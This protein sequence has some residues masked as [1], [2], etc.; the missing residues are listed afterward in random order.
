MSNTRTNKAPSSIDLI[1]EATEKV[2]R[3][4]KHQGRDKLVIPEPR[5][6]TPPEK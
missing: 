5:K 4:P 1:R 2:N 6:K 3:D